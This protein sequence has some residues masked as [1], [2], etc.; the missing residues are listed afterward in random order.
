MI[1]ANYLCF[2]FQSV[3]TICLAFSA[4]ACNRTNSVTDTHPIGL[5]KSD[6]DLSEEDLENS[7]VTLAFQGPQ[8]VPIID[9]LFYTDKSKHSLERFLDFQK[10][11]MRY[12]TNIDA[13]PFIVTPNEMRRMLLA[14]EPLLTQRK[15]RKW[16]DT[17]VAFVLVYESKGS[18]RG[19]EY[20][21][22]N[23]NTETFYKTLIGALDP[24]N[25][26][27]REIL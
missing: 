15:L 17:N 8:T 19:G 2:S 14:V 11:G 10:S 22:E 5:A 16:V 25:M 9:V 18:D 23:K 3:L 24:T 12:T 26:K 4:I 20:F 1:R 7:Q 27:G 6:L 13:I 21:V